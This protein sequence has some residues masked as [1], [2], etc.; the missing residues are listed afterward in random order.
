M[1]TAISKLLSADLNAVDELM[2]RYTR[3]TRGNDG[4]QKILR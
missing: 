4:Q 1:S 2:K 3:S